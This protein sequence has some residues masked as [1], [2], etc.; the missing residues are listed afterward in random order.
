MANGKVAF[1]F[2][3]D[4]LPTGNVSFTS[5]EGKKTFRGLMGYKTRKPRPGSNPDEG[6][7]PTLRHW[8]FAVSA[9][10]ALHPMP[11][12]QLRAHVLFSDDGRN[13]WSAPT[14]KGRERVLRA[15]HRARRSQCKSW[16]NDDWRDRLLA[17]MA[18]LAG[19]APTLNLQVSL[20]SA[21]AAVNPRPVEFLSPVTLREP[22]TTSVEPTPYDDEEEGDEDA[23]EDAQNTE[24]AKVEK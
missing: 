10:P 9:R 8:H 11:M 16:W 12:L 24:T 15:M 22:S 14:A 18:W 7:A 5:I 23:G 1:Y 17:T 21:V 13:L 19:H 2:D 20:G 6:K 4:L 3:L